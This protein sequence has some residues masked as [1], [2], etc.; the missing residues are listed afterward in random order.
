MPK[1]TK[2]IRLLLIR[3]DAAIVAEQDDICTVQVLPD[4]PEATVQV[5]L[6]EL[7]TWCER[8]IESRATHTGRGLRC[9]GGGGDNGPRYPATQRIG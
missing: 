9:L 1:I 7:H 2:P 8:R 6:T 3:L 5:Q 4:L